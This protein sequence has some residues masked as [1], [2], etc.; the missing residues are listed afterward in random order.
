[1][2]QVEIIR[3]DLLHPL[4]DDQQG[5]GDDQILWFPMSPLP[6]WLHEAHMPSS[7]HCTL[8]TTRL[9]ARTIYGQAKKNA[10]E[11]FLLNDVSL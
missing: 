8:I 10:L 5:P 6:T 3:A 7:L 11:F 1:M 9:P 2:Y 4:G